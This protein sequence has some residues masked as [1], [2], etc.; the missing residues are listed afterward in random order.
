MLS[1]DQLDILHECAYEAL[2]VFDGFCREH[3]ISYCLRGGS[4]LG[5]VKY[6]GIVPWDDDIDVALPR[7]D[8]R[9]LMALFPAETG[10]F[11]FVTWQNSDRAYCYFPRLV[12]REERSRQLGLPLNHEYGTLLVD[13]LPIDAVPDIPV[14]LRAEEGAVSILRLLSSVRTLESSRI[15]CKRRGLKKKIPEWMH[16]LGLHHFY[17][18]AQIFRLMDSLYQTS[19]FGTT[20]CAG[21][22]A[23]SRGQEDI[24]PTDWWTSCRRRPFGRLA[25]PVPRHCDTYLKRLF[26]ADYLREEPDEALREERSHYDCV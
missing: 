15:P 7:E 12:L 22:L 13:I 19:R 8:Y 1:R 9:R 20:R 24:L 2:A 3:D 18:Q 10:D 14:L 25:C 26:G 21:I 16:A 5:A 23:G 4:A 11:L 6:R 17:S